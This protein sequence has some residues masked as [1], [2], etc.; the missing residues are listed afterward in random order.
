VSDDELEPDFLLR[1][2]A[3]GFFPMDR[4]R[5]AKGRVRWYAPD[6]RAILPLD[7]PRIE[8]TLRRQRT[9][10]I[11]LRIDTAFD[12]VMR[13]CARWDEPSDVW[14]S[15]RLCAAY[16]VLHADGF[17]HS[18]EAWAGTELV[19]GLYGVTIGRAFMAESMFHDR[20]GS[21]SLVLAWSAAHLRAHDFALYDIQMLSPHL[22]R[23]GAIEIPAED[24]LERLRAAL[25]PPP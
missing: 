3:A 6:P 9:H 7:A 15:E 20:P 4:G 18:F 14:I 19:A 25:A 21:G 12:A 16:G 23:L 17:A 11:E 10:A 8:R 24:Y 1:A 2:Y 22:E 13:R 5:R